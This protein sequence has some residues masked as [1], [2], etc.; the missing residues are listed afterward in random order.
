MASLTGGRGGKRWI[1]S[2][3]GAG[4]LLAVAA[5]CLGRIASANA[6]GVSVHGGGSTSGMT[7]FAVAVTDGT[8]H[9]EC[10]MPKLMTVEAT[11]TSANATSTSSATL[12]GT[13]SVT[14]SKANPFGLPPGPMARG[15]SFTATLV[16]GG[17]GVGSEGLF[18][19]GMS[20]PGTLQHGNI[21]MDP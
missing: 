5:S 9:F 17:P 18:I 1:A 13:A 3:V 10:L 21:T 4:V 2:V 7:R 6:A 14:L 12:S 20:F 16:A 11:V 15:V 19:L 8:G